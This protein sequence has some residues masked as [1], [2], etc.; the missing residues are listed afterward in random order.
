MKSYNTSF[1]MKEYKFY[2]SP[3]TSKLRYI[4][5]S[6]VDPSDDDESDEL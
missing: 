2:M 5:V 1:G 3:F 4:N 6:N